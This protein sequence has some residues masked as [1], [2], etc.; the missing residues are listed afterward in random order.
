MAFFDL[1]YKKV[2]ALVFFDH[3]RMFIS[4][5]YSFNKI[6][7]MDMTK[8]SEAINIYSDTAGAL[9][10]GSL[11]SRIPRKLLDISTHAIFSL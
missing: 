11:S 5:L 10:Y 3:L 8:S 1:A 2:S 7:K 4:I 9:A 6:Q